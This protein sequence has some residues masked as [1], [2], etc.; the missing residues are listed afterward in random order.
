M[1][2]QTYVHAVVCSCSRMFMQLY[3]HAV[4]CSCSP[5][6]TFVCV[7]L[8]ASLQVHI[9]K[10]WCSYTCFGYL[11]MCALVRIFASA[12]MQVH[13]CKCM[14][15]FMQSYEQVHFHTFPS[16]HALGTLRVKVPNIIHA[17]WEREIL[18]YKGNSIRAQVRTPQASLRSYLF[19]ELEPK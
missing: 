7:H 10:S 5:L 3:V 11:R 14:Y 17:A 16:I 2:I 12:Y 1:H 8:C 15:M 18:D 4:V 9:C 19:G 6:D 13:I